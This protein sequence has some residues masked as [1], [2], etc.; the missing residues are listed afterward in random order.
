MTSTKDVNLGAMIRAKTLIVEHFNSDDLIELMFSLSIRDEDIKGNTHT[1]RV[2][3]LIKY[4]ERHK[5]LNQ[6]ILRCQERRPRVD[7]PALAVD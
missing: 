6:L 1:V 5:F 2:V 7:W 4:C 3:E